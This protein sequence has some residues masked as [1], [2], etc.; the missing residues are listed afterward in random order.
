M[1]IDKGERA[2]T[3]AS[4]YNLTGSEATFTTSATMIEGE[5]RAFSSDHLPEMAAP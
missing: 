1:L 3:V 4:E 2:F 5:L